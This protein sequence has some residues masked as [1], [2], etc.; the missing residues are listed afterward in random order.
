MKDI[1]NYKN[2]VCAEKFPSEN[3]YV[4]IDKKILEKL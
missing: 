2:D 4:S 3:N 1:I